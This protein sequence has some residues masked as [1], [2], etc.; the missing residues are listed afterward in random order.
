[1]TYTYSQRT[2]LDMEEAQRRLTESLKKRGF[3][4]LTEI[5]VKKTLKEKL[6]EDIAPCKILGAC[7]PNFAHK[8]IGIE[9]SLGAL[10]PCNCLI[11]V[12]GN[13]TQVSCIL[14]T[15]QL[16]KTGNPQLEPIAREVEDL[17][18]EAV[19]EATSAES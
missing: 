16:A 13:S 2:E 19:N 3:G 17:L 6:G 18:K 4:I 7:N 5:D 14:P 9:P 12:E 8:A 10:L 11:R 15:V 1:M